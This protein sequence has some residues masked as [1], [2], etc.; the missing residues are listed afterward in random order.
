MSA[1]VSEIKCSG[2]VACVGVC[3][4]NAIKIEGKKASVSG[5]CV[6]CGRC[7]GVCPNDAITFTG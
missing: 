7:A 1:T 5:E 2:C 4:V 6:G 3:P